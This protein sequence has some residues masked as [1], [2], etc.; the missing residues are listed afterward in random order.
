MMTKQEALYEYI[1][2]NNYD[3]DEYESLE[4]AIDNECVEENYDYYDLDVFTI[5]D[6]TYAV[7]DNYEDA[8]RAARANVSDLLDDIGIDGLNIE[9]ND[10]V[11]TGWFEDAEREMHVNYARDIAYESASDDELYVNRLHEELCDYELMDELELPEEP[12]NEDEYDEW[13]KKCDKIKK[14]AEKKAEEL[15]DDF[16]DILMSDDSVQY[17][18]ENFGNDG[19]NE[20]CK[21]YNLIDYQELAEEIVSIDGVGHCLA[22]YD[23]EEHEL[24]NKYVAFRIN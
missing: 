10:F 18:I 13:E 1:F 21:K 17:Y 24:P 23:G 2:D 7:A 5:D 6:G 8:E 20:I 3:T 9:I 4:E 16:A 14:I 19:F 15:I 12:E 22:S 11:D